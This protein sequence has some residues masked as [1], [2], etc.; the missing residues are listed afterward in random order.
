[1]TNLFVAALW[2][3]RNGYS[4]IPVQRN[5][6][7]F[8]KWEQYQSQAADESQV[9]QWWG[10]WPEANIG[11]VTG[12]VSSIDVVDCDSDAGRAALEEFLPESLTTPII[13]TPKGYHVYFN[14]RPGL[15]NGVRVLTDCDLRTTG[16]Y[17]IAPPSVGEKGQ[18]KAMPG[19]K[20]NEVT[21]AAM[22]DMLF[23]ILQQGGHCQRASSSEH[24]IGRIH[25]CGEGGVVSPPDNKGQQATTSD[26]I[27]FSEGGRDNALFHLANHLVKGGMPILNIEKY[28]HFF[29]SNCT[30]PFPEKEI[31]AKIQSALNRSKN[32]DR[33]LTQDI[34]EWFLTTSDNVTTTFLYNCQHL[35]TRDQKKKAQVVLGRLVNEGFI[36]RVSGQN[37]VYR[38]IESD[39][40]TID[41]LNAESKC[42][43]VWLPFN[44]HQMVE[45]MPGNII[46]LAGEPNAGKTGL[47]LNVIRSNMRRYEVHYYNS[48]MGAGELKKRLALFDDITLD[49]WKFKAWER[50]DNFG[51][52]IKSGEGKIN[53]ID[54]L[55]LHDN[56]YEIGG[57]L[58]E[59]HQKLKGAIAI[60][61][62]Q[63]N[64]GTDTGLGG[65][66]SLEKPRLALA[67]SPGTLKIVKAKNWKA[68]DNPN[69]KQVNFKVVK[70]CNFIQTKGWHKQ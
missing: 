55:E 54:F 12:S 8:I 31:E 45:T 59:I 38:R 24:I 42:V 51:D 19:L 39:C 69:G 34:R 10:K 58:A 70:G 57:K 22:P 61:A 14:H 48:E 1:M 36:E 63:K 50:S 23:D 56:F 33:N 2:Y 9:R 29:G 68:K 32:R 13:K 60:V 25:S 3:Q 17:V 11:I 20:I 5:K 67:M 35:T 41:F 52:V 40:D 26:N 47:L 7:P 46:L 30:P 49:Q 16:G 62:L 44:L 18:Y 4:V 53:I 28:L 27:L 65:F 6:K 64:R 15:S 43:D 66:R 37:G 21:P